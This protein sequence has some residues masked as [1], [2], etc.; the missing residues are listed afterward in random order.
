MSYV[1]GSETIYRLQMPVGEADIEFCVYSLQPFYDLAKADKERYFQEMKEWEDRMIAA[2]RPELVRG[3]HKAVPKPAKKKP[4]KKKAAAKKKTATKK[5]A[6]K[7]DKSKSKKQ[8]TSS[9]NSEE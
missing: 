1:L 7:S 8:D 6:T 4:A 9:S 5:K 2:G 3:Y